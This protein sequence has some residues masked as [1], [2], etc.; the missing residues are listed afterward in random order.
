MLQMLKSKFSSL[1]DEIFFSINITILQRTNVK[2]V[3]PVYGARTHNLWNV[4]LLP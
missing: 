4:S 3:H 1:A 2:N